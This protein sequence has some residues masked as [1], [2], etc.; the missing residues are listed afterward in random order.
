MLFLG[1][2][3]TFLGSALIVVSLI[4][5]GDQWLGLIGGGLAFISGM[6][7]WRLGRN[8]ERRNGPTVR[9]LSPCPHCDEVGLLTP[10]ALAAHVVRAHPDE[11]IEET[12]RQR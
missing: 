5:P 9:H 7:L 2:I 4:K 1:R 6:E 12:R 8:A 11:L 3:L 10:T